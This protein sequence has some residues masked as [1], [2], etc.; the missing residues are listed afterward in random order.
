MKGI[1]AGN[2][3]SNLSMEKS[4]V[5]RGYVYSGW[6]SDLHGSSFRHNIFAYRNKSGADY[7]LLLNFQ[8]CT[9]ENNVF[10]DQSSIKDS[11]GLIFN[12]NMFKNTFT[13][14][15]GI[16]GANNLENVGNP[17]VDVAGVLGFSYDYNYHLTD[18]SGGKNAATDGTNIGIYGS[19][20]PYKEN[21]IPY[22]PHIKTSNV[23]TQAVNN[24][25]GVNI[26]AVAQD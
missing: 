18:A 14:G 13:I 6:A 24:Q 21:A 22:Y 7:R 11:D 20:S 12:N 19:S 2:N 10:A 4:L 15:A 26:N 16:S 8:S 25:L 9:F 1:L 23:A 3:A 5:I 17:F